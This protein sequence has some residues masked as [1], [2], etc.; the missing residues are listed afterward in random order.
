MAAVSFARFRSEVLPLYTPPLRARATQAK[1]RQVLDELAALGVVRTTADLSPAAIAAWLSRPPRPRR[2]ES[3]RSL[4]ATL[5]ALC[6]Y[7]VFRGY[8]RS[9]PFAWRTPSAWLASLPDAEAIDRHK[10]LADI[11]RV[12]ALADQEAASGDWRAGRLRAL[13]YTYAFTG[14][15]RHEALGLRVADI[16][17]AGG[18]VWIRS[19]P[20]RRL[21]TRKAGAPLAIAGPLAE[22]LAGWLPRCACEW[23]F[24]GSTRRGPWLTGGP[25]VRAVDQLRALGERAGVPGLSPGNFRHSF[26][27][28]AESWGFG[29]L[30]LQRWLRHTNPRTQRSYRQADLDSLRL[31]AAKIGFGSLAG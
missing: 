8:L 27:T 1:V 4:L 9:D 20:R 11:R 10:P 6:R 7:A 19:N 14:M 12:L 16:D 26:G 15:R 31:A 29:E 5:R 25:G 18:V 24:P 30:E 17:L 28:L 13:V 21:K 23:A 3:W 2:P 22:V